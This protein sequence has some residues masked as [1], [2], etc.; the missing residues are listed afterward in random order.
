MMTTCTTSRSFPPFVTWTVSF[1]NRPSKV[2]PVELRETDRDLTRSMS[3]FTVTSPAWLA[4]VVDV[5][6]TWRDG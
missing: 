1:R 5:A 2:A 4:S 3:T 6:T